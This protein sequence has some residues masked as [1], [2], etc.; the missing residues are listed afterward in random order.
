MLTQVSREYFYDDTVDPAA[1]IDIL[2]VSR[3][4]Y[5]EVRLLN[6]ALLRKKDKP[7]SI[8]EEHRRE[9]ATEH[10]N[11]EKLEDID[12]ART[13]LQEVSEATRIAELEQ[14]VASLK[15][16][17]AAREEAAPPACECKGLSAV[18]LQMRQEGKTDEEIAAAL[19]EKGLSLSQI[20]VTLHSDPLSVS[21]DAITMCAKRLIG[22]AK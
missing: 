6:D 7:L 8:L 10:N 3:F 11:I 4:H 21:Q 1:C 15:E 19:K 22:I 18:V 13:E 17:P 14:E 20:G 2:L 16:R 5:I 9:Y 12:G